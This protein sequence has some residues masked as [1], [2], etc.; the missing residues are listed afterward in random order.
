MQ[1]L[2][3]LVLLA[4][5]A[6][7]VAAPAPVTP[8]LHEKRESAPRTWVKRSRVDPTAVLPVRIGLR[9]RNLESGP[10]LLN[11]VYVITLYVAAALRSLLSISL[12]TIRSLS[13]AWRSMIATLDQYDARQSR[14]PS[15]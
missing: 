10:T 8:V 1:L 13:T 6:F 14:I 2:S 15:P 12:F 4:A 5:A 11:E 9:Q 3:L 7:T